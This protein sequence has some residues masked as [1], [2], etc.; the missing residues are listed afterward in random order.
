MKIILT[1]D[2][3]KYFETDKQLI[4]LSPR[5]RFQR[6]IKKFGLFFGLAVFCIFIP[7]F[8]F[9]LV[10]LFLLIAMIAGWKTYQVENELDL[11]T[12]KCLQCSQNLNPVYYLGS[13][14][15]FHCDHCQSH[16]VVTK[17]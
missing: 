4:K 3:S 10:P 7:V 16:Y 11:G 6:A 14:L 15:R 17:A 9:I 1:S 5:Q 2:Q 13:D 8:H 12:Q